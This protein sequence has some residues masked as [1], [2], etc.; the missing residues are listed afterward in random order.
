MCFY[1][2]TTHG[3]CGHTDK[4]L[5][6]CEDRVRTGKCVL[7]D[8]VLCEK[9]ELEEVP[10]LCWDCYKRFSPDYQPR[11]GKWQMANGKVFEGFITGPNL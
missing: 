6:L 8:G 1:V 2:I 10:N 4:V 3:K 7:D 11:E 5:D 9:I